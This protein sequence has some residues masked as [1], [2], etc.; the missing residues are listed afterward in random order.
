MDTWRRKIKSI[1]SCNLPNFGFNDPQYGSWI[2]TP[3]ILDLHDANLQ[4]VILGIVM[5]G[6]Y[7]LNRHM[8]YCYK[9]LQEE[10]MKQFE[11]RLKSMPGSSRFR[12]NESYQKGKCNKIVINYLKKV[13]ISFG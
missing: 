13:N 8:Q 2:D 12:R 6:L 1:F 10:R 7:L 5:I 9:A 4:S 11:K 3:L